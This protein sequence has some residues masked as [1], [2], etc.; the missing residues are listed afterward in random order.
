MRKLAMRTALPL[1][2]LLFASCKS[3]EPK[4]YFGRIAT[5][6]TELQTELKNG[7][8]QIDTVTKSLNNFATVQGD[9]RPSL[10]ELQRSTSSLNATTAEIQSLGQEVR[11]KEA[12]FQKSWSEDIESIE[13]ENV[14]R[15]AQQ[16]REDIDSA[17]KD[18][19]KRTEA[20]RTRYTEWESKVK[21]IQ[22]SFESDLSP[23]NQQALT[24]KIKEVSDLTPKLKDEI[25]SLSD[26]LAELSRTMKSAR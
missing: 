11:A 22:T 14:R 18:L 10:I 25:R 2:L 4:D 21:Q 3:S 6:L 5:D 17:F 13:S 16:G 15:T 12:A 23:A 1:L 7:M 19:Q 26:N 24:A 9:L 8:Y 20:V